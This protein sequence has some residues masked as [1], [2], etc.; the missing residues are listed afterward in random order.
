MLLMIQVESLKRNDSM[1]SMKCDKAGASL[2]LGVF[3]ILSKYD[4]PLEIHGMVVLE[5]MIGGDVIKPDDVF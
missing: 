2:I 4:L 1:V 3:E 5:N